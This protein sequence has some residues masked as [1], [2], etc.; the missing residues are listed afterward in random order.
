M[1]LLPLLR[2]MEMEI[3]RKVLCFGLAFG[4]LGS[5]AVVAGD[6]PEFS[7]F[8]GDY[9]GFEESPKVSGAWRYIKPGAKLADLEKY[10]K[11]MLEPIQVWV[12]GEARFK[13]VDPDQLDAMTD[14]FHNAVIKAMAPDY[15]I[16]GNP[17]DDVLR[18]SMAITGI[19]PVK[20]KRS[21]LGYVPIA[22][23]L[24]TA[25]EAVDSAGGKEA[26]ELEASMEAAFF[27]STS[28]ER[29]FAFVDSHRGDDMMVE[30]EQAHLDWEGTKAALDFWAAELRKR[31]DET[32][33]KIEED[34]PFNSLDAG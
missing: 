27:D 23:V 34:S 11:I 29:M 14:Y 20:P 26:V 5:A 19:I 6:K 17:G 4:L 22:F 24:S 8:L 13:G 25:K 31:F 10:N 7:G 16:V 12:H 28:G 2:D 33:G 1:W 32:H 15:P 3:L 30:K 18:V 21:P 9:S